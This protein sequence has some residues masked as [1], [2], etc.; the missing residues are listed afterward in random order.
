[1]DRLRSQ[2][3]GQGEFDRSV[4]SE[5]WEETPKQP[6]GGVLLRE[7]IETIVKGQTILENEIET[8]QSTHVIRKNNFSD[9][10]ITQKKN[11]T[12][13]KIWPPTPKTTNI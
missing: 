6:N 8:T 5:L 10:K 2:N 11:K 9:G 12:S 7:Y 4:S 1:M 13:N 3:M